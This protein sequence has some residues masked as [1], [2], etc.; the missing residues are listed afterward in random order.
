MKWWY[1]LNL[2]RWVR[3]KALSRKRTV[4]HWTYYRKHNLPRNTVGVWDYNRATIIRPLVQ[5][6]IEQL[7]LGPFMLQ[8]GHRIKLYDYEYDIYGRAQANL[9]TEDAKYGEL[10]SVEVPYDE[11]VN[12]VRVHDPYG[13]QKEHWLRVPA[14][15][16]SAREAVAWT[17]DL[18]TSRYNPIKET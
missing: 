14:S 12:A 10:W 15:I 16:F 11:S 13:E 17:F 18:P 7:G 1:P 2:V 3:G 6:D 9:N 4:P 8:Y 5:A